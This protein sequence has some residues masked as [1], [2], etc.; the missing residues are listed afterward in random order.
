MNILKKG[1]LI[2][3]ALLLVISTS[4]KQ[5]D[6]LNIIEGL[7]FVIATLNAKGN[8]TGVLP[9][10]VPPDGRILYTVD[11][12]AT[13]DDD[14][15]VF[16]TS[17]PMV[18]YTYPEVTATYTIMVTASLPGRDDVSITKEHTVT[19]N[20]TPPPGGGSPIEGRWKLAPEAGALGVGPAFL[21][22][23]FIGRCGYQ[24]LFI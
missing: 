1:L 22:V 7:D 21:V 12:G 17:G 14:T 4:C 11:F 16:Q 19:I 6:D 10:T 5:D 2:V 9:S 3:A 20:V 13:I 18:T 8:K 24:S 15:D 23:Q